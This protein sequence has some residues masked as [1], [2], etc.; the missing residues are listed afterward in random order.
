MKLRHRIRAWFKRIAA[1][2]EARPGKPNGYWTGPALIELSPALEP[3]QRRALL[4]AIAWWNKRF[5]GRFLTKEGGEEADIGWPPRQG[6][7]TAT[8]HVPVGGPAVV[9]STELFFAVVRGGEIIGAHIEIRP[10]TCGERAERAAA[11]EL[12]HVLGLGHVENATDHLMGLE[13]P[14]WRLLELEVDFVRG[15]S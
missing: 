15:L 12:G 9:A 14:G 11:H 7:V 2:P 4:C 6:I 10:G 5:P 3:E 8:S 1:P 13:S